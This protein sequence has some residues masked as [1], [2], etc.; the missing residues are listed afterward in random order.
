MNVQVSSLQVH[1]DLLN[2]QELPADHQGIKVTPDSTAV[3]NTDARNV[4]VKEEFQ[5]EP[6]VSLLSLQPSTVPLPSFIQRLVVFN[7]QDTAGNTSGARFV[8]YL[9]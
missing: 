9:L 6:R 3:K 8:S 1:H 4:Q 7:V 2:G 5:P